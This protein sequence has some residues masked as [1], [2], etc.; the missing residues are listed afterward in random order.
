MLR[1]VRMLLSIALIML[2]SSTILSAQSKLHGSVAKAKDQPLAEATV[3]LLNSKD[4]SLV[5][6][7]L[8]ST[9]GN[10][11]FEKI[12]PGNYIVA[13]SYSG[14]KKVFSPV[15]HVD[16][17]EQ[18]AIE[19][20][21]LSEKINSLDAVTVMARK[22]LFEQKVDRM[23]INVANNITSAGSTVLD[24]LER[25]PGI[26]VDRQNNSLSING[27]N[28]VVVMIN[29]RIN[30]MPISAV[31]QMLA[32]MPSDNVEKVELI[33]TPPAN[34]DAEGN[35]GYIN[36]VL[37][38]NTQYGTNGSYTLTQGY[39]KGSVTDLA[40]NFN[41]REARWNL[42]GN[43]S[44]NRTASAQTAIFSHAV[45]NGS[46]YFENFSKSERKPVETISDLKLGFD[47][48]V[49]KNLVAGVLVSLFNRSWDMSANN[50]SSVY[51]NGIID[52]MASVYNKETHPL[53]NYDINLNLQ[54]NFTEGRLTF[55]LDYMDYRE[56][57]PVTY[58]NSYYNGNGAFLYEEQLRSNKNTPVKLWV[59]AVDLERKL[60]KKINVTA[61][62]KATFSTFT[63]AVEIA[64]MTSGS[65]IEDPSLTATYFL[66]ENI[67][68]AYSSMDW[69]LTD[70]T[71]MKMGLRYEY[72]NSNLKTLYEKNIV[73]RHYGRLFPSFFLSHSLK[74]NNSWSFAYSRR[75]TRPTFW[76]LAPFVIFMDP[77]TFM[78]GNPKLQPA[79]TDNVNT[80]F[81]YKRKIV[82]LS[83]S[84]EA[85]PITNFAPHIDPNTN[86]E[87]LSS[88]NQD[89]SISYNVSVSLPF[90]IAKWWSV[91]MSLNGNYM[92]MFGLY[93]NEPVTIQQESFFANAIQNFNLPKDY[94]F[95]VSG[96]YSTGGLFGLYKM[97]PLGSL[98]LGLQ[99]KLKN[100]KS[101]LRL[102]YA[103]VLNTM[104]P[105]FSVNIPEKNLVAAGEIQFYH[106]GVRLTFTH[107]FGSD[108]VKAKRD[109]STG[110]EEEKDSL[111]M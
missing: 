75:I 47:Y 111:K 92:K 19:A 68:A 69:A 104:K 27:K 54:K 53:N 26:A 110:S 58:A 97:R 87:T 8:T 63:N 95:S 91:Q 15:V 12:P 17:N 51:A 79:I 33:T 98:D 96:F 70:K 71:N 28:G 62:A 78:S 56:K 49:A 45:R 82:S 83:Y 11:A 3:L 13:A 80:S 7:S 14:Y 72:T 40:G 34:F 52:T 105:H 46:T 29:G 61:G 18:K 74:D 84:Y 64:R 93:N 102:N 59:G 76:N 36:I 9:T 31:V 107:N 24:V 90:D 99:K 2:F 100:K 101:T 94:T 16:G 30:H 86:K 108:K 66:N 67:S 22:P 43:Y 106:P 77:N 23:V 88:E 37:K 6:G 20:L 4:S 44:F 38:R 41:H 57:N 85:N 42:Y 89:H 1:Y 21:M 103:N 60:S 65:W 50:T 5:K 48:D 25:S 39:S 81:T 32:G 109:R 73:D 10:Y 55:N 35:A